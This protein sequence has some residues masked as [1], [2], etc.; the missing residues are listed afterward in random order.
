[1]MFFFFSNVFL[2]GFLVMVLSRFSL[3][4]LFCIF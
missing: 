4:V 3:I 2:I 1:V